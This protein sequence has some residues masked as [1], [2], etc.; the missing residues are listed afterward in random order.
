M[1]L[2]STDG[3]IITVTVTDEKTKILDVP[4]VAV[5][6]VVEVDGKITKDTIDWYAQDEDGNVWYFGENTK[7]ANGENMLI[8]VDGSW[9]AGVDGAKPGIIMPANGGT[10]GDVYRQEWLLNDAEDVAEIQ[11][12]TES[13]SAP[14][15]FGSTLVGTCSGTCV[16]IRDYRPL[17][18]DK[19]E[20]KFYAPGVG[21]IVVLDDNDHDYREELV[22]IR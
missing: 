18:P 19:S 6:D 8:S 7:S 11:S 12:K 2:L 3:E 13:Q 5:A 9:Q 20:S 10:V 14:I 4:I 17:E 22:E 16:K 15:I 1:E 21:V